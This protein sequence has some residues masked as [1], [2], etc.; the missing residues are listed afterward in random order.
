MFICIENHLMPIP[1]YNI[2]NYIIVLKHGHGNDLR[3]NH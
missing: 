1:L 2:N 3:C